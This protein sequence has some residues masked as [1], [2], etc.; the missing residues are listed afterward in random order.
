[1]QL[2]SIIHMQ[3]SLKLQFP[4]FVHLKI[5]HPFYILIHNIHTCPLNII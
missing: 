2:F 3:V 4:N 5:L 1:M